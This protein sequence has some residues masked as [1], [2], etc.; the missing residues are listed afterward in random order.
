M[1]PTN[2]LISLKFA[3]MQPE[4]TDKVHAIA[5]TLPVISTNFLVYELSS[6]PFLISPIPST[7]SENTSP[8]I[9]TRYVGIGIDNNY[10][11]FNSNPCTTK[12]DSVLCHPIDVQVRTLNSTCYHQLVSETGINH[13]LGHLVVSAGNILNQQYTY[14]PDRQKVMI[15]TPTPDIASFKLAKVQISCRI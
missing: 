15:F 1:I 7:V 4:M 5:I 13:C 6:I 2:T 8:F 9:P 3:H 11:Q 10:F 12:G 14:T